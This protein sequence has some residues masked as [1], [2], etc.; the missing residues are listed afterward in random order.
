ML[1]LLS[2]VV[3]PSPPLSRRARFRYEV[4]WR[5]VRGRVVERTI[6]KALKQQMNGWKGRQTDCTED[7][8]KRPWPRPVESRV[9]YGGWYSVLVSRFVCLPLTDKRKRILRESL[10]LCTVFSPLLLSASSWCRLGRVGLTT[11]S[12]C[13]GRRVCNFGPTRLIN[14]WSTGHIPGI[15]TPSSGRRADRHEPIANFSGRKY[16]SLY[17]SKY[18]SV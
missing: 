3:S 18:V 4:R 15:V 10:W 11:S 9:S 2:R 12:H 17:T 13:D 5:F 16:L 8:N 7:P 1:G 14:R 6:C